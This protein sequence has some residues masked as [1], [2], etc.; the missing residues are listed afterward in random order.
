MSRAAP[1]EI[2]RLPC[3]CATARRASRA[4]TQ[5]YDRWLRPH[6]IEAPQFAI[7]NLLDALGVSNQTT[8]GAHFDL[9]KTTLSRNLK[10]LHKN[11]WIALSPGADRRERN[12]IL[13]AAGRAR[14]SAAR[15][16]WR[17]AQKAMEGA[18]GRKGWHEAFRTLDAVTTA[19]QAAARSAGS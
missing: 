7:L 1:I 15:P 4:I 5:L 9:D 16:A 17:K 3:A 18:L 19:A 13:T 12:V 11:G 2:A 10:L 8:I 6:G 14:L